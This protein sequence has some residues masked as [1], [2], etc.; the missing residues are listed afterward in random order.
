MSKQTPIPISKVTNMQEIVKSMQH[1]NEMV[2]V[3]D[4]QNYPQKIKD[5]SK[6][7]ALKAFKDVAEMTDPKTI[8]RLVVDEYRKKRKVD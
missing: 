2:M 3:I 8:D 7:V 6:R 1:I 4:S 5:D